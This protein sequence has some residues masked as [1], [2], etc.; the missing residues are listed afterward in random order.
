[1]AAVTPVPQLLMIGT[2]GFMPFDSKTALSLEAGRRVLSLGSRRSATGT[3]MEK[4]MW[5]EDRPVVVSMLLLV[6]TG[7]FLCTFSGLW[8]DALPSS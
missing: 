4:G 1:M 6:C 8:V 3:E 5:P 7:G 2:S